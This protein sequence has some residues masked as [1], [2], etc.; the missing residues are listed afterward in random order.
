MSTH[1]RHLRD[2]GIHFPTNVSLACRD[3]RKPPSPR[4]WNSLLDRKPLRGPVVR[5]LYTPTKCRSEE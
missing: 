4:S 1:R 5:L 3:E 2:G